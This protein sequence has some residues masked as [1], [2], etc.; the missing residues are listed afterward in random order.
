MATFILIHGSWHGAWRWRKVT[1]LL[2]KRGHRVIAPDL[3]GLGEDKTP[4]S[5][6]SHDTWTRYICGILDGVDQPS[7]LVE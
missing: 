7:I 6:V 5:R 2:E 1:P 3:P 4:L